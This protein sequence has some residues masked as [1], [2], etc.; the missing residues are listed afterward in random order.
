ML[1]KSYVSILLFLTI[2][3][4]NLAQDSAVWKKDINL[5][6]DTSEL[7]PLRIVNDDKNNVYVLSNYYQHFNSVNNKIYLKKYS[8]NGLLEWTYIFDKKENAQASDLAI[9]DNNNTYIVGKYKKDSS[10]TT[11]LLLKLSPTGSEIWRNDSSK[12]T[13]YDQILIKNNHIYLRGDYIRSLDL[14]GN[15]KWSTLHVFTSNFALDHNS[16]MIVSTYD[17]IYRYDTAGVLNFSDKH[18]YGNNRIAIDR[19]NSF[20][21]LSDQ[22]YYNLIKYDSSGSLLWRKDS[23]SISPPFGDIGFDLLTDMEDNVVLV[24]LNDSI[25]KISPSGKMIWKKSMKGLDH[26]LISSQISY[27]NSIMIAGS[28]YDGN[29]Y[30][31]GV[32]SFNLNG[33]E[34][35]SGA[36]NGNIAKQEYLVDMSIDNSTGIYLLENNNQNTSLIKFK[37]PY[38]SGIKYELICLDSIWYNS[39]KQ[40]KLNIFNGSAAFLNYPKVQII[41][42]NGDTVGNPSNM[43]TFFGH[44]G[45]QYQV[46]SYDI[47]DSSISNFNNYSFLFHHSIPDSSHFIN[48]C[49]TSNIQSF[50][51]DANNSILIYPNPFKNQLNFSSKFTEEKNL[52][53]MLY[54]TSGR[55]IFKEQIDFENSLDLNKLSSGMYF[56]TIL[57]KNVT[58]QSGKLIAQ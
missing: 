2:P 5:L 51:T 49:I 41:S 38:F 6:P 46:Y 43:M 9:D 58:I 31:I 57:D 25:I 15:E 30:S 34:N 7:I 8:E 36:F 18:A 26:Y 27:N 4:C 48:F 20:Y 55:L 33:D 56:Y 16:Q 54:D 23:L 21:I 19:K 22:Q 10:T 1:A 24:G 13:H 17:S 40:I 14:N 29:D 50:Q 47:T 42:P 37:P 44:S 3:F 12:S 11:A 52:L 53:F 45:N 35:W 28:I 32:S 39:P